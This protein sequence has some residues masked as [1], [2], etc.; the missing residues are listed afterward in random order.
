MRTNWL[1]LWLAVFLQVSTALYAQ[2][3]G[4]LRITVSAGDLDRRQSVV[5]FHLPEHWAA[6]NYRMSGFEGGEVWL[7]VS[8]EGEATFRLDRLD[9]GE[10]RSYQL[11]PEQQMESDSPGMLH[12]IGE[13]TIALIKGD[14]EVLQYYHRE[15]DLPEG[16]D[17]IYRRAGY[18]H[19]VYSPD[20]V[21][22]TNHLKESY[23]HHY[24]IWSAW[25]NTE[26]QGRT[27]DFWNPHNRSGRVVAEDSLQVAWQG[28]VHTGFRSRHFFEDLSAEVPVIALNEMWEVTLYNTGDDAYHQFDLDL[29]QTVNTGQPLKLPEYRY[30]GVGFRGHPDWD[31]PENIRF[32]TSEGLGRD[33]HAT[34]ARWVHI[35]GKS[36][37]DWAGIAILSHPE[38]FRH[39]QTVRIHPEDA[40]FNY[41]PSQLGDFEIRTSEPYRARYRYITTDGEADPDEIERLWYDYAYPPGVTVMPQ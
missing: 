32:L 34:R 22:L 1:V 21:Q 33:G 16:M 5:Q 37:G 20:G 11:A 30:G 9:A 2:S 12:R 3:P 28:E 7:Q 18:I 41:A 10:A 13:K 23:S 29:V 14:R 4:P 17:S 8:S 19:P 40:F 36:D 6:G 39:P 26:F 35:G 31:D 24:G 25:T 15:S 27:P 38:N